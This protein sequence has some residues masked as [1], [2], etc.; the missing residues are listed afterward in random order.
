MIKKDYKIKKMSP[1]SVTVI[2][3]CTKGY[4]G[5]TGKHKMFKF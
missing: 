2:I 5:V 1:F 3:V 4:K